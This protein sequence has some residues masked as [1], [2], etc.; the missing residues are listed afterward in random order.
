M[1]GNQSKNM[2]L[3]EYILNPNQFKYNQIPILFL[4]SYENQKRDNLMKTTIKISFK[5]KI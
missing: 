1:G 5:V 4:Y 3:M 2:I